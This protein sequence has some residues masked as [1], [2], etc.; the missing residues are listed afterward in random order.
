MSELDIERR[1]RAAQAVK[2]RFPQVADYLIV[3][4]VD[5]VIDVYLET[6]LS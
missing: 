3:D 1:Q 2:A 5:V 4:L 6:G